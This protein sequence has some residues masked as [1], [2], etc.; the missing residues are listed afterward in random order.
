MPI[1]SQAMSRPSP[2]QCGMMLRPRYDEVG[3]PCWNTIASPWPSS[4]YAMRRPLTD[5]NV[6]DA[7]GLADSGT[8]PSASPTGIRESMPDEI[9]Q[10]ADTSP[11]AKVG[12][13]SSGAGRGSC[14]AIDVSCREAAHG[15]DHGAP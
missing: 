6:L 3:L 4:M 2:A 13:A 15:A 12:A 9:A 10:A 14:L 11:W 5:A 1:K 8:R 7:K